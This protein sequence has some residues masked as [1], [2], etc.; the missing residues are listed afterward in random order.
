[1]YV[2]IP[3]C[4]CVTYVR[5]HACLYA[6]VR[7]N[8]YVCLCGHLCTPA[9]DAHMC[10][11]VC[12]YACMESWTDVFM[13]VMSVNCVRNLTSKV[14]SMYIYIIYVH[15]NDLDDLGR[16]TA[17]L[18]KTSQS[19]SEDLHETAPPYP[20]RQ[21]QVVPGCLQAKPRPNSFPAPIS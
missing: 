20:R 6:C 3:V 12:V 19:P 8:A 15:I 21:G 5:M 9:S 4:V 2:Y 14:V 10:T 18:A 11:G 16:F 13:Y 7:V 17:S 1:M